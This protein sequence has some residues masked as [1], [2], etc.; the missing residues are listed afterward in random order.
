M[1]TMVFLLCFVSTMVFA[2]S[3]FSARQGIPMTQAERQKEYLEARHDAPVITFGKS[4]IV[5]S[6]PL[7]AGLRK[8]PPQ[9]GLSRGQK[10]LRLPIVRLFVPGPMEKPPGGTGKYFA[11][12]NE[13]S[14]LPWPAAASRPV[15]ARGGA[16]VRREPD[17]ALVQLHK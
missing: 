10:F 3:D 8:L 7:V 5:L 1:K 11:W 9:E 4:D 13:N 12:R 17:S 15:G 14:A 6:G 16:D 2:Q